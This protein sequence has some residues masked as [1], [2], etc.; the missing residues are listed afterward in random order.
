MKP[1]IKKKWV[2]ALR[3]GKYNQTKDHLR[4]ENGYCCLGVLCEIAAKEGVCKLEL[5]EMLGSSYIVHQYDDASLT[6]PSKV[7]EW[8]GLESSN[9]IITRTSGEDSSLSGLNDEL[10]YNF[11]Q[12]ADIIEEQL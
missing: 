10:G 7:I 8:A 9:P 1:E 11:N 3:S 12:I 4:D 6:L 5:K 2:A